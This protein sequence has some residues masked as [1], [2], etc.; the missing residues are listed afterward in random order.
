M[1]TL[2][3]GVGND[4]YG[5]DGVGPAV[6]EEL[7]RMIDGGA[8]Y[9]PFSGSCLDFL[10]FIDGFDRVIVVDSFEGGLI[11]LGECRRVEFAKGADG[12]GTPWMSHQTGV[13]EA[14]E[15]ARRMRLNLPGSLRLYG[16]GTGANETA[17]IGLSR[18]TAEAVRRWAGEILNDLDSP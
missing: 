16:I 18:E 2:V 17:G 3:V 9:R 1:K 11:P 12:R 5:D 4:L 7:S 8:E 14:L 15:L 10:G 6:A 13:P